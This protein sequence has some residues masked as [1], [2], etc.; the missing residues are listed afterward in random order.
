[1]EVLT[2]WIQHEREDRNLFGIVNAI[3]RAGQTFD[4]TSWVKFDE[5]GGDLIG[6]GESRWD[7]IKKRAD[8][9]E[10]KEVVAIFGTD[11]E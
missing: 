3:T 7:A 10:E 4:N 1:M 5:L 2:Q 6:M 8:T 11:F 9:Y